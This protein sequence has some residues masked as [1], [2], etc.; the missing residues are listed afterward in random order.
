MVVDLA[1]QTPDLNI[2]LAGSNAIVPNGLVNSRVNQLDKII[3]NSSESLI[4]T[5]KK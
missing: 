2:P 5:P 4:E 1:T 3:D